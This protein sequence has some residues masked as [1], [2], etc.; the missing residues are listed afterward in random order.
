MYTYKGF[1]ADSKVTTTTTSAGLSIGQVGLQP[2][3]P[4]PWG[5][6]S[7][8]VLYLMGQAPKDSSYTCIMYKPC[9]RDHK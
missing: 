5:A 9:M 3:G 6:P 4:Q 8:Q 1:F 2:R 7:G